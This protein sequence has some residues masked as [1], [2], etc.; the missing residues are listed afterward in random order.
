MRA[1][2]RRR[3]DE[4]DAEYDLRLF[5]QL[6]SPRLGDPYHLAELCEA[7][8]ESMRRPV[9]ILCEAPPRHWKTVTILHH[10]ARRLKYRPTEQNAYGTYSGQLA[11]RKSRLCRE[12]AGR[13]GVFAR[14]EQLQLGPGEKAKDP[15]ATVSF[16]Q[17]HHGG[18]LIAGGRNGAY[19]GEGFG[20]M[21]LDDMFKNRGEA[22]SEKIQETVY[23]DV[24]Q[25][26]MF[27]R[28]EPGGSICSSHQAWNDRDLNERLREWAK[29]ER[30]GAEIIDVRLPAVSRATYDMRGRLTGGVPLHPKRYDI[31]ALR[32][33]QQAIDTYNFESQYQQN[34]IPRGKRVFVEPQRYVEPNLN[35]A[36]IRI[37]CDPGIS[38]NEKRDP[39]GFLVG[40]GYLDRAGAVC[41]DILYA[42]ERHEEIPET[43][44]GLEELHED[45]FGASILLEEVSAFKAVSQVARR[46]DQERTRRGEQPAN[47]PIES[48]IP[49]GSKFVRSLP[50]AAGVRFGRVRV[51][52]KA[53]WLPAFLK[54]MRRFTGRE[55]GADNMIDALTQLYD[56]F[57]Q[58]LASS[59]LRSRTGGEPKIAAGF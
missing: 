45:W 33:I 6:Y 16:W 3:L 34:R 37:S 2:A 28:L 22:E 26:T 43:V 51:P 31:R 46:L 7:L 20:F 47:L 10:I 21:Y 5:I 49:E 52:L 48:W 36:I 57:D 30:L 18:G 27:T 19:V 54:Q 1:L 8:D 15:A 29:S 38:K 9:I 24:F 14:P 4:I 11:F 40:A 53:W 17:T 12:Y 50:C 32:R 55:G 58:N 35:G 23:E 56:W 59:G 41:L 42:E 39:S 13:A 44:D 25:G